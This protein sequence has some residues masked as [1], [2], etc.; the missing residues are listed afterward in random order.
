MLVDEVEAHAH[1]GMNF[2]SPV[3]LLLFSRP[4]GRKI[5][6]FYNLIGRLFYADAARYLRRHGAAF[7]TALVGSTGNCTNLL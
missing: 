2:F 1:D 5:R 4:D 6:A 7:I 3:P